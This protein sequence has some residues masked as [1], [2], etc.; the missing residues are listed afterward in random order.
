[1]RGPVAYVDRGA[2]SPRICDIAAAAGAFF[3]VHPANVEAVAMVFQV[4]TTLATA[5]S[6]GALL[7]LWRYPFPAGWL[8][9]RPC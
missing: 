8:L 5:L 9:G 1:M 3:L 4:K 6:F 7:L 2:P